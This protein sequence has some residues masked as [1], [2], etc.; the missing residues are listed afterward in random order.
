MPTKICKKCLL[1]KDLDLY[2]KAKGCK[3]GR[4]GS[5]RECRYM[6]LK[7]WY[8]NNE[9]KKEVYQKRYKENMSDEQ[10][11]HRR[12]Y[13]KEYDSKRPIEKRIYY[14]KRYYESNKISE[15]ERKRVW[16]T[17][18]SSHVSDY[19][20]NQ[21]KKLS[22]ELSDSYIKGSHKGIHEELIPLKREIIK[23][24]RLIKQKL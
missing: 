1:D 5:C 3:D 4:R 11:E 20:K 21:A 16:A 19:N 13:L 7:S 8:K 2:E 6:Y 14:N 10:R 12:A 15:R 17:E 23:L 9:G 18:N 24:Q 22:K